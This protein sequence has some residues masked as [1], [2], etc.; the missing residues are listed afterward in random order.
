MNRRKFLLTTLVVAAPAIAEARTRRFWFRIKTKS[1]GIMGATQEAA[2]WPIAKDVFTTAQQQ[3][4][5]IG[6]SADTPKVNPADVPLY[7]KYGYSAWRAGPGTNYSRDPG[8]PSTLRQADRTCARLCGC[9]QCGAPF[10]VL[11]H[12]R[13][14]YHRQG[15]AGAADLS[16]LER[17]VRSE[18]SQA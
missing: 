3:I 8:R 16:R 9:A 7:E 10:D 13:H 15:I 14:S 6:L 12:Q 18:L 4:L 11:R 5:P 2:E 1:G 17:S